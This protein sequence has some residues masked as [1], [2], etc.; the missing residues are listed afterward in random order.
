MQY[1]FFFVVVDFSSEVKDVLGLSVVAG[2]TITCK[3][4][5]KPKK[6]YSALIVSNMNM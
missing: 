5:E 1:N 4:K 6:E 2:Q 3:K